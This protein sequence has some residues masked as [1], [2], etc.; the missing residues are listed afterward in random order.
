VEPFPRTGAKYQLSHDGGE[1]PVW[2]HDGSHLFY[3]VP[4]FD[5]VISMA[6]SLNPFPEVIERVRVSID[7]LASNPTYDL[8]FGRNILVVFDPTLVSVHSRSERVALVLNWFRRAI[9]RIS[10]D[11]GLR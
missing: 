8:S 2:S 5:D 3:R 9:G 4:N 7:G 6:I 1:M 10:L 11:R